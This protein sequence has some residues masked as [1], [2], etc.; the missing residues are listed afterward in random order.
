MPTVWYVHWQ[1]T[2]PLRLAHI[3][4]ADQSQVAF[5]LGQLWGDILGL[6]RGGFYLDNTFSNIIGLLKCVLPFLLT[7]I[8]Q[9]HDQAEHDPTSPGLRV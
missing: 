1:L 5:A 3:Q 8:R 4:N 7:A 9:K 6:L 2:S